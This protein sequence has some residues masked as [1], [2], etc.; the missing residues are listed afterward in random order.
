M[1]RPLAHK[2]ESFLN[3]RTSSPLKS[4][5]QTPQKTLLTKTHR[6]DADSAQKSN[7]IGP[8][9]H[10]YHDPPT[11]TSSSSPCSCSTAQDLVN[12]D[13]E[14]ILQPKIMGLKQNNYTYRRP[15]A[16]LSIQKYPGYVSAVGQLRHGRLKLTTLYHPKNFQNASGSLHK[17]NDLPS[18]VTPPRNSLAKI[19]HR[20]GTG[21]LADDE[22][23][24]ELEQMLLTK[25]RETLRRKRSMSVGKNRGK[26]HLVTKPKFEIRQN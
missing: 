21:A 26:I 6:T 4:R 22:E 15:L 20:S 11:E 17:F 25:L 2:S 3:S 10:I 7:R 16:N 9:F 12:D 8:G 13:K 23:V 18:Y 1:S 14:N 24:D 19:L 5:S